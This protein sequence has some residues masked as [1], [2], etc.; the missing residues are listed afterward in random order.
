MT[1]SIL[2]STKKILGLDFSYTAFD[3]DIITH[4]NAAFSVLNQLGIGP[5]TGFTIED[6]EANWVDFVVPA[7]QLNMI[8]TYVYLKVR[9]FFDPPSTSYLI[10]AMNQQIKELEWRLSVFR[11]YALPEEVV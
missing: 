4:I 1:S 10:E 9:M 5:T 3:T 8:K 7:E 6:D 11:E 2:R